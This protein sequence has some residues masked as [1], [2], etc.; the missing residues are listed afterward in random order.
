MLT[1]VTSA[2]NICTRSFLAVSKTRVL[3]LDGLL[4]TVSLQAEQ[5]WFVE[6]IG[7]AKL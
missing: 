1:I 4:E 2:A 5:K 3:S 6:A 7:F